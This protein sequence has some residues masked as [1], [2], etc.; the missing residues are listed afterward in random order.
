MD[1]LLAIDWGSSAL[2]GALLDASGRVLDERAVARGMLTI[3]PGG[4]AAVFES[5]FGDWMDGR[6]GQCLMAG[7]VGSKQG[8]VEAPYC[9]CPAGLD[10][11]VARLMPVSHA[12]DGRPRRIAIVPGVTCERAGVPD[13]MR[14][15]EIKVLGALDLLGI[16]DATIVL[17]GTHSKWATV[18]RGRI[19]AFSTVMSGEFYALLRQHSILARSLPADGG[20]LDAA[21]FDRGVD[22]ALETGS[23]M[24]SAF[25]VRTLALFDRLPAAALP[26][27]LS[28]LVIGEELRCRPLDGI[29]Q[30]IVIGAPVL[31]ERFERALRRR[32]LRTRTFGEEAAW[33][34]LWAIHRRA[35]AQGKQP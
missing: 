1:T 15:E 16:A 27:Y 18:E 22:G 23:L 3:E 33:R 5:H 26:S 17:P 35:A 7:M 21:A 9:P 10:E 12:V 13:V 11:I 30:L 2:R 24:Q 29:E 32:G 19:V 25:S 14:G 28:G 31:A 6:A 8:W 34:G 20:A 4:F